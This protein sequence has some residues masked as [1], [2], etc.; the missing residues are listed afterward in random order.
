MP[1]RSRTRKAHRFN[2]FLRRTPCTA[3][4][5]GNL[6]TLILLS[7]TV[8]AIRTIWL[9]FEQDIHR[10]DNDDVVITARINYTKT[11]FNKVLYS[12]ADCP[13]LP[14]DY[15]LWPCENMPRDNAFGRNGHYDVSLWLNRKLNRNAML[16]RQPLLQNLTKCMNLIEEVFCHDSLALPSA[17]FESLFSIDSC[18]GFNGMTLPNDNYTTNGHVYAP[19][20]NLERIYS[21]VQG[22]NILASDLIVRCPIC[23]ST[24]PFHF[25][26]NGTCFMKWKTAERGWPLFYDQCDSLQN[27]GTNTTECQGIALPILSSS[28]ILNTSFLSNA[29]SP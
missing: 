29:I 1:S 11:K 20:V 12:F 5:I 26:N 10:F 6:I 7:F 21:G 18:P 19:R 14:L 16:K 4:L 15:E 17:L 24:V 27:Y 25:S 13:Y 8:F 28:D 23:V 3:I 2:V 22:Q 9:A